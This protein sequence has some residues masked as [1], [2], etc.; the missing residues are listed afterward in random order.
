MNDQN[1]WRLEPG[2]VWHGFDNLEDNWVMLDPIKVSLIAPGMGD[3]GKLQSHGVPAQLVS[4]YLYQEGIVPTRTTDFQLMF[5]FSMGITCGKWG[6]LINALLNFKRFYD[7]NT[8]VNEV[9]PQLAKDHPEI[10]GAI[11]LRDLCDRMFDFIRREDPTA[12]LNAAFNTLPQAVL[13]PQA[14]YR[15]I[16]T[17]DVELVP[18]DQLVNRVSA[19]SLI[20]YPPGIPLLMSGESFGG[21]DSPQIGYLKS[22]AHW[23]KEFPGFEHVTEGT[24][25]RD[26]V[27]HVLCVK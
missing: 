17:G 9:L 6:T 25:M 23:D 16:V 10:Y 1:C 20:P 4:S 27:C 26:G 3:N 13:T 14:A 15:K 18:T 12:K 19:N 2:A 21:A 7:S 24:E 22:L 8:P 11:G 5:L